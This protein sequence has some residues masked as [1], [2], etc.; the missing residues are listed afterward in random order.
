MS[1]LRLL[2]SIP[3]RRLSG[4]TPVPE[5]PEDWMSEDLKVVYRSRVP[6]EAEPVASPAVPPREP[7][8]HGRGRATLGLSRP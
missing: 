8:V 2:V 1:P 4:A 7:A 3:T 5:V 6:A